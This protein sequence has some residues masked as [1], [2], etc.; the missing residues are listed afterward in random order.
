ML[1]Y[2]LDFFFFNNITFYNKQFIYACNNLNV[3]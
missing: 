2:I 1:Y 3:M